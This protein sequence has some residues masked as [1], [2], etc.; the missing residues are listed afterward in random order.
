[1]RDVLDFLIYF[2]IC[3][4]NFVIAYLFLVVDKHTFGWADIDPM[5]LFWVH[6]GG[7]IFLPISVIIVHV[8]FRLVGFKGL[9]AA[10]WLSVFM[11]F[12]FRDILSGFE[13]KY[14]LDISNYIKG[15]IFYVDWEINCPSKTETQKKSHGPRNPI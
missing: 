10:C 4:F 1:M 11:F 2:S 5:V 12:L 7:A 14:V 9:F 8:L 13:H 6:I 3:V 15:F